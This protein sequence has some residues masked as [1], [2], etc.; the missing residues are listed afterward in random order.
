[1]R[2]VCPN[3]TF[4]GT[5][6]SQVDAGNVAGALE[7]WADT[8]DQRSIGELGPRRKA[9]LTDDIKAQLSSGQEPALLDSLVNVWCA[10]ALTSGGIALINIAGTVNKKASRTRSIRTGQ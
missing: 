4:G 1:V 6:I 5:Y 9:E 3:A 7:T 8:L 2:L 10:T